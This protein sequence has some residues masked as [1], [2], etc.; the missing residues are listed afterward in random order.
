MSV[1][2]TNSTQTFSGG[3]SVLTFN[4]RALTAFPQYIQV[5]AVALTGGT[6][7]ALSYSTQYTVTISSTG[8]GGTVIVLPTFGSNYNYIVYRKT[9][10]LQSSSYTDYNAFPASTLENNLDQ[11]TMIEQESNTSTSLQFSY[12]VGT[13]ST[14]STTVP[15]PSAGSI[16]GWDATG[17]KLINTVSA[18][19]G[20]TGPIGPSGATGNITLVSSSTSDI[21]VVSTS[22]TPIITAVNA[23]TGGT[24]TLIRSGADGYLHIY[25]PYIKVSETEPSGTNS[26]TSLLSGSWA[27]VTLN[28][29]DTDTGSLAT[30]SSSTLSI[31]SGT[32]IVSAKVPF[33]NSGGKAQAR[34]FNSTSGGTLLIGQSLGN[35]AANVTNHSIVSGQITLTT[36][37]TIILQAQSTTGSGVT[38]N[39]SAFGT[40]VYSILE[41]IKI[42]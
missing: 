27:T 8:I 40:E 7:T 41:L 39:N 12:P 13:S 20:S 42:S 31:P 37:S 16:L 33:Y 15:I 6:V 18:P 32:Y 21:T 17:T 24:S 23:G 9:A 36:T 5:N 1:A 35:G 3:Q 11:L 38:G 28:T 26:T 19:S 14:Y 22:T 34:L 30:L 29:K 25:Y 4:F 2:T 10:I